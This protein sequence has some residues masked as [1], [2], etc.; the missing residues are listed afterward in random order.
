MA[1]E[2]K[3]IVLSPDG[4]PIERDAEYKDSKE[5]MEALGRFID[6]YRKQ[7]YYSS[8]VRIPIDEIEVNCRIVEV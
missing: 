2:I 5:A 6:K 8:R 4:F 3:Y 7:G 1:K